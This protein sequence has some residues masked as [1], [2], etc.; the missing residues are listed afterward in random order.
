MPVVR[1]N[2]ISP[3]DPVAPAAP[4]GP[5][6]VF[7]LSENALLGLCL[8]LVLLVTLIDVLTPASL[9]VG[10]LLSAP[11]ALAALGVS[12]AWT[13]RLIALVLAGNVFAA[14][15]NGLRDGVS[16]TD[17]VNRVISVLAAL[18]V[19]VLTLRAREASARAARLTEEGRRLSRER[20][21][22]RVARS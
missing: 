19:G 14:L 5:A 17:L 9:V 13:L 3:A 6:T 7:P 8:G 1:A 15:F 20:A 21:G 18:L 12:R 16:G 10:T 4:E 11:I 22:D 2:P